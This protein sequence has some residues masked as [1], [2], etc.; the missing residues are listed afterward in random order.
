[1]LV[2]ASAAVINALERKYPL[3]HSQV[4]M[5]KNLRSVV[6]IPWSH[7]H[8]TS[9]CPGK[10]TQ[11]NFRKQIFAWLWWGLFGA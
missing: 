7:I 5:I 11:A 1:M 3:P 4:Q 10:A 2:S 6:I 8:V 9:S